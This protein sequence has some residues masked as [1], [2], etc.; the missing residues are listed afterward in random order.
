M[1][2]VTVARGQEMV[3]VSLPV[4]VL[5]PQTFMNCCGPAV[6]VWL[7]GMELPPERLLV[8]HDDL[9]LGVGRLRVVAGGGSGGPPVAG[10]VV[11]L[12]I[13]M[14]GLAGFYTTRGRGARHRANRSRS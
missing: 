1:V 5:K 4:V 2:K 13:A 12:A 11:L 10:A 14:L 3:S 6:A 9:D 7:R 8:V